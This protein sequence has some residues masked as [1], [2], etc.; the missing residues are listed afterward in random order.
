M[1]YRAL[2]NFI[3]E[4]AYYEQGAEYEFET[5]PAL[6]KDGYLEKIGN[7]EPLPP[8]TEETEEK[9]DPPLEADADIDDVMQMPDLGGEG[10]GKT[11]KRK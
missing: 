9:A 4:S 11:I 2:K 10:K 7:A 1:K 8:K 6:I 3:F 5:V